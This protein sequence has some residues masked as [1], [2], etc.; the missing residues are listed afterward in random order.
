M[1]FGRHESRYWPYLCRASALSAYLSMGLTTGA[2]GLNGCGGRGASYEKSVWHCGITV[3]PG[4]YSHIWGIWQRGAF[5][6]LG[7]AGERASYSN[8][9]TPEGHSPHG[10]GSRSAR[11]QPEGHC[12]QLRTDKAG[13]AG[14]RES[15]D[16]TLEMECRYWALSSW[17]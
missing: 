14:T 4:S 6:K 5:L 2:V 9:R 16:N 15:G 12:S 3:G 1:C 7:R 8:S 17:S 13:K 11:R 10:C